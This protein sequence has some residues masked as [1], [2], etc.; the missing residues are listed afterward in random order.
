MGAL[1]KTQWFFA[2]NF[3]VSLGTYVFFGTMY[4]FG[5]VEVVQDGQSGPSSSFMI[6][7]LAVAACSLFWGTIIAHPKLGVVLGKC[8]RP[9]PKG[10]LAGVKV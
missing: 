4:G 9:K 8:Y 2:T 3:F 1:G 7:L 6:C 10:P 5:G